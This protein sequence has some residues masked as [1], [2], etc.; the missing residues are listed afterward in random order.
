M[1]GG[2][3]CQRGGDW[4]FGWRLIRDEDIN[5]IKGQGILSESGAGQMGFRIIK[6]AVPQGANNGSEAENIV[7]G[8]V[9]TNDH[10]GEE[11]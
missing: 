4:V 11:E 9:Y 6:F 8:G 2:R 10:C 7:C 5:D 3:C 1:F